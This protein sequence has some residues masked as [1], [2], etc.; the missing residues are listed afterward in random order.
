ME[1]NLSSYRLCSHDGI[2]GGM[3]CEAWD[4]DRI[5]TDKSGSTDRNNSTNRNICTGRNGRR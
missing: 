5:S 2:Y 1:E 4:T 3:R